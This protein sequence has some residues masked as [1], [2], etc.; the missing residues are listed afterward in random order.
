MPHFFVQN[1]RVQN[2]RVQNLRYFK[3]LPIILG[4]S[5]VLGGCQ[6]L[7]TDQCHQLSLVTNSGKALPV[8]QN[9]AEFIKLANSLDQLNLK[10]QAIALDDQNLNS[11]KDKYS[12]WYGAMAQ[13]SRQ[14]AQASKDQNPQLLTQAQKNLKDLAGQE[15]SLVTEFNNYCNEN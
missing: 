12:Q 15:I 11:L 8:V 9:A 2:L 4:A 3:F 1:L 5:L 6:S 14:I 13:S 10:V 7:K